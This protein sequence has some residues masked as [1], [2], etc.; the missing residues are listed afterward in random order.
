MTI[1]EIPPSVRFTKQCFLPALVWVT[2]RFFRSSCDSVKAFSRCSSFGTRLSP[3]M[4]GEP[5]SRS[6]A[7]RLLLDSTRCFW[8]CPY[9]FQELRD[10]LLLPACA[11]LR[12]SPRVFEFASKQEIEK[13]DAQEMC[14]SAARHLKMYNEMDPGKKWLDLSSNPDHRKRT[15]TADGALFT[16]T[17]NTRIW[18]LANHSSFVCCISSKAIA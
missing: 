18:W 12:I 1:W 11:P 7:Y 15:E 17:T 13:I 16:L 8:N 10:V 4:F 14:A 5:T 3:R 2:F 9:S 6:R